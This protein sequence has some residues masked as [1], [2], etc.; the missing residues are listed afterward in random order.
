MTTRKQKATTPAEPTEVRE[1]ATLENAQALARRAHQGQKDQAGQPVI[2]HLERVAGR[3]AKRD[4]ET[5]IAA[6]LH[7]I[8]EDSK[9]TLRDLTEA[10]Y[11]TRVIEAVELLSRDRAMQ[12]YTSYIDR[13][14]R[15]RNTIA[16]LVKRADIDD[17]LKHTPH[18][19]NSSLQRRYR[20]ARARL[21]G[22]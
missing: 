17:H 5:Q 4:I 8:V 9:T 14:A 3:V 7:D 1:P 12:T 11:S 10:G 20:M 15:S 6:W 18:A 16:L 22:H 13:I 19:I 21:N 2:H